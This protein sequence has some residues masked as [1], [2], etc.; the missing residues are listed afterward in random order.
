MPSKRIAVAL[1]HTGALAAL[2]MLAPLSTAP[3]T[4]VFVDYSDH[5]GVGG[6]PDN[7]GPHWTG[8]VD[9]EANSLIIHT[10]TDLP[11]T[12]EFWTPWTPDL[13]AA[14]LVWPAVTSTGIAYDVPDDF[15]GDIDGAFGFVSTVSARDMRWNEGIWG[16]SPS[17]T[18]PSEI[19]FYP[20]WGGVR[21]PISVNGTITLVY[22]TSADETEMPWLPIAPLGLAGSTGAT[23]TVQTP[24]NV[25]GP[26]VPEASAL[27]FGCVACAA[28][29]SVAMWRSRRRAP[30]AAASGAR[31]ID[32]QTELDI[33]QNGLMISPS[34]R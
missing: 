25:I 34:A 30:V 12:P 14:P 9:T 20:G 10:W 26:A 3:A 23:V 33:R 15:L 18:L 4:V 6:F 29:L 31:A 13:S 22:D 27:L 8:F 2:L 7:G 21:K 28:G 24:A 11:G 19:D 1:S 32:W 17:L 16:E 5:N